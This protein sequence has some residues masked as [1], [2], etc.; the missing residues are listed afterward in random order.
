MG[1]RSPLPTTAVLSGLR[2]N[3]AAIAP[4]QSVG[5]VYGPPSLVSFHRHATNRWIQKGGRL[6]GVGDKSEVVGIEQPTFDLCLRRIVGRPS[7]DPIS[8]R[9]QSR[10]SKRT[11]VPGMLEKLS[12]WFSNLA[13]HPVHDRYRERTLASP[14]LPLGLMHG[15]KGF[16][17][18]RFAH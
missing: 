14:C 5:Q 9:R 17:V 15:K 2:S 11:L 12:G 1:G 13:R 8:I 7:P 18:K 10:A 3:P 4:V 6:L 16:H